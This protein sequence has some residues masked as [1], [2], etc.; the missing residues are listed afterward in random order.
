[1]HLEVLD[2]AFLVKLIHNIS[3]IDII[4]N[5]FQ[6]YFFLWKDYDN[7]PL[8]KL[9]ESVRESHRKE[10]IEDDTVDLLLR[11]VFKIMLKLSIL[12]I[13]GSWAPIY[14]VGAKA[15]CELKN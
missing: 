12:Q 9:H 3:Y 13:K 10:I 4:E 15:N 1:M 14:I 2:Y 6:A 5:L 7:S 8:E 11:R